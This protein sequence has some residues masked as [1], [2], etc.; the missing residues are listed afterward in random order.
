MPPDNTYALRFGP[1]K[2]EARIDEALTA[3]Q[4][5][6]WVV[7]P[8][9]GSCLLFTPQQP[10]RLLKLLDYLAAA[11]GAA[12]AGLGSAEILADIVSSNLG[13]LPDL[14]AATTGPMKLCGSTAAQFKPLT[15][16]CEP[17]G[18]EEAPYS[19]GWS[20][21]CTA[22]QGVGSVCYAACAGNAQGP[23]YTAQCVIEDDFPSWRLA[24]NCT[25]K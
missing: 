3:L 5:G 10:L 24:G 15:Y 25:R 22:D 20:G 7:D 4:R 12:N 1:A 8:T 14:S 21:D 6:E 23:G 13:L 17:L 2:L 11:A 19:V 16:S 9:D 18:S